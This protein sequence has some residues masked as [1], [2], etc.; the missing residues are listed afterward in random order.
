MRESFSLKQLAGKHKSICMDSAVPNVS[1]SAPPPTGS[2]SLQCQL[3]SP[4]QSALVKPSL[5]GSRGARTP[6]WCASPG[7]GW[8]WIP[9][10][11]EVTDG[12]SV[13]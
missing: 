2:G 8:F 11:K 10:H 4:A 3:A 13:F 1:L 12:S 9:A 6:S 5:R 7:S